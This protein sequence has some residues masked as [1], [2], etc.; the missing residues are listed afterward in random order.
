MRKSSQTN[1]IITAG[2]EGTERRVENSTSAPH[3]SG[4]REIQLF[5][6]L[7]VSRGASKHHGGW[8]Q[9]SQLQK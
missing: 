4:G 1:H 7:Q 9:V 3:W 8:F 5:T 6:S 2:E